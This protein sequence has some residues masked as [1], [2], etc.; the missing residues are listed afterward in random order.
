MLSKISVIPNTTKDLSRPEAH[1]LFQRLLSGCGCVA[2]P[3][4]CRSFLPY[5]ENTEAVFLSREELFLGTDVI[6]ILGGDGSVI[7]AARGTA[8]YGIPMT[9]VNFGTVGYLS[10]IEIGDLETVDRVLTGQ[11]PVEN[12]VML[13]IEIRDNT[14][15]E[16]KTITALNEALLS[17]GPITRLM[18]VELRCDGITADFCRANGLV[19]ATP[20]GST[21]YSMS[22]GGP[23]LDPRLDCLCITPV[24]SHLLRNRPFILSGDSE[25]ELRNIRCDGNAIY[26]SSDGR[27]VIGLSPSTE[28]HIRRSK[29]VTKLIRAKADGFLGVL[30]RK[31]WTQK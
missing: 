2:L 13:D 15:G 22:A 10:E 21:G 16:V 30:N 20:T 19:I 5:L 18:D 25:L 28:V 27:D 31:M 23:V 3:D 11:C 9:A 26:L 4:D 7:D 17:N 24:C 8:K 29:T 12:R 1:K 6:F 14:S